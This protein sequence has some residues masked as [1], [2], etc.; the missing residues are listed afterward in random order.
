VTIPAAAKQRTP[1]GAKA[2]AQFFLDVASRAF[3][4]NDPRPLQAL[5]QTQCT[6]CDVLVK[7]ITEQRASGERPRQPRFVFEAANVQPQT[8][9]GIFVVD[10]IGTERDVE[11]VDDSG[12]VLRR[13]GSAPSWT[14]STLAW[15]NEGWRVRQLA[16]VKK[17]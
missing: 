13:S 16:A 1:D 5:S 4:S 10:V 6:G 14:R 2:F 12:R 3:V 15:T 11:V 8:Q 7:V 17:Q 9:Q